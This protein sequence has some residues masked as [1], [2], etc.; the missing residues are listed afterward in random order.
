MFILSL[1]STLPSRSVYIIKLYIVAH[2]Q[3][4]L[5]FINKQKVL[6]YLYNC[7]Y[8]VITIFYKQT[9]TFCLKYTVAYI[10]ASLYFINKQKVLSYLYNCTY[11]VITIL[12]KQKKYSVVRIQSHITYSVI[13]ILYKQTKKFCLMY[14][15]AY[16]QA[17]L[18]FI[19]KQKNILN[20]NGVLDR[21]LARVSLI[22]LAYATGKHHYI[23][24]VTLANTLLSSL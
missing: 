11:S 8:S 17:S 4:S 14:T 24:I 18:Y 20:L 2:I 21:C 16:I 5:Y 23:D 15:I 12:H 19:N 3:S 1:R 13:A 7:T 10:H 22:F 6:S 9:K